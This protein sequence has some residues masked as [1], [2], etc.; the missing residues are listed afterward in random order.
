MNIRAEAAAEVIRRSN[1][2][3]LTYADGHRFKPS[4]GSTL[5]NISLLLENL[6]HLDSTESSQELD[7]IQHDM[8]RMFNVVTTRQLDLFSDLN[9]VIDSFKV[10][11]CTYVTLDITYYFL[12]I[13][14]NNSFCDL[15][16]SF[17]W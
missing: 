13:S 17:L 12:N 2:G 14:L 5:E 10:I 7:R 4:V 6:N 9:S 16:G 11:L 15:L 1:S 3:T 8:T